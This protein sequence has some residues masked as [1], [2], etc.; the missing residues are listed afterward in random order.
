MVQFGT[1]PAAVVRFLPQPLGAD[2]ESAAAGLAAARP[3]GPLA[4]F[5]VG[6]AGD[7]ARLLDVTWQED[8][9]GACFMELL[10]VLGGRKKRWKTNIFM[11]YQI[12]PENSSKCWMGGKHPAARALQS[13]GHSLTGN[14]K[15]TY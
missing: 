11:L 9:K 13:A 4:E 1:G 6:G 5:T 7:D 8:R 12:K 15:S 3:V 10:L 2:F 14:S